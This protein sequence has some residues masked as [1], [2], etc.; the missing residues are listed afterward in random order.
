M[1][2]IL[3]LQQ[4]LARVQ[5][6]PS[7]FKLSEPNVIE[8]VQKLVELGLLEVLFTTNGKEYLT[9][10][11]LRHEV[12][13]EIMVR[14]GRVNITELAPVLNV[15]LP[16]IER[17]V[18]ALLAEAPS[19][20][21]GQLQLFQGEVIADYYLDTLAEEINE[22]LK[23]AGKLMIGELAVKHTLTTEFLLRL[24]EPRLGTVIQA[25]LSSGSL[26]TS[27]YVARHA[28][29]V[30]GV[31]TAVTRPVSLPQ[32]IKDYG[33]TE[34]LF[35][36]C[37]A[38]LVASGRLSGLLHGKSTFT[39]SLYVNAQSAS[40]LAFFQQNGVLEYSLL[41]SKL[42]VKDPRAYLAEKLPGGVALSSCYMNR[43]LLG[44]AEAEA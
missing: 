2:E 4:E 21:G 10:K 1:D 20:T 33:F 35:F 28:A 23:G 9:P 16:H 14:G 6:A 15:D 8:V 41:T 19:Q 34:G 43:E 31:L 32:L 24:V 18:N 27:A 40:V 37:V 39:P 29:K 11:Q 13:D 36:D 26:Y 5:S 17:V 25:K 30:R 7:T 22:E 44:A 42:Q 38:E 12:E 3:A